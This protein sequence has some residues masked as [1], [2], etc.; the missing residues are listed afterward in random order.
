VDQNPKD[1][2]R[3]VAGTATF[4]KVLGVLLATAVAMGIIFW[5]ASESEEGENKI[6][7]T[8]SRVSSVSSPAASD[9]TLSASRLGPVA[10]E[11]AA[12]ERALLFTGLGEQGRNINV[13]AARRTSD[14]GRAIWRVTFSNVRL[15][16][17]GG[18]LEH[19]MQYVHR[20]DVFLDAE[21]GQLLKIISPVAYGK[22]VAAGDP[23]ADE[24][25]A[26]FAKTPPK[27]DF[28][29]ALALSEIYAD[30]TD[31]G[32]V[33]AYCVLRLSSRGTRSVWVLY[34]R[35]YPNP[36]PRDYEN[37]EFNIECIIDAE[38]GKGLWVEERVLPVASSR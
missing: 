33:V 35:G 8:R 24:D 25:F 28:L 14:E 7:T 11:G 22:P 27:I 16:W 1:P 30:P 2:S 19:E 38:T 36:P 32:Q 23:S 3:K 34:Y 21:T 20:L 17:K 9:R 18:G 15:H 29:K 5:G 37:F 6:E 4:G 26:G 13:S 31:T 10:T 12:I